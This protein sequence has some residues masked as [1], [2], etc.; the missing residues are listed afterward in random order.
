M[1]SFI[2]SFRLNPHCTPPLTVFICLVFHSV[3]ILKHTTQHFIYSSEVSIW[4]PLFFPSQ[5]HFNWHI[6][7]SI[8]FVI[9]TCLET[10]KWARIKCCQLPLC[11][12]GKWYLIVIICIFWAENFPYKEITQQ[13]LSELHRDK[14]YTHKSS[15]LWDT[16]KLQKTEF[17]RSGSR[18]ALVRKV[19]LISSLLLLKYKSNKLRQW[20]HSGSVDLQNVDKGT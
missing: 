7:I 12:F 14:N 8:N 6:I 5:C 16:E 2:S 1:K 15:K 20:F 19:T 4:Q 9:T 11:P 18:M 3:Y 17:T 13:Q 10:I